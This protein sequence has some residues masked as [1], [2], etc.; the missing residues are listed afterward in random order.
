METHGLPPEPPDPGPLAG[1]LVRRRQSGEF[2]VLSDP[3]RSLRVACRVWAGL[4]ALGLV[5]NH[6][7]GPL[8]S[9]DRPLDDAWPWPASPVAVAAILLSLGLLAWTKRPGLRPARLLDLALA[10]EVLLALG[11]GIVNQWTP[12]TIG[13]SWICVLILVHPLIV[14]APPAKVFAASFAAASMDLVGLAVSGARGVELPPASVLVWTYLPNYLCAML[15]VLPAHV[16]VRLEHHREAA[17]ELGS[18][19]LGELLGR[20][21]MGE[22]YRAEHRLLARPAAVKIVR[23]ELL[24]AADPERFRRIVARFEREARVTARLCSPHTVAVYDFG[25][26]D[27]GTFYYVMELLDGLDLDELVRENGP[28]PAGRAVSVLLQICDSLAEAHDQGLVH[29]DIKPSN[30]MLCRY[31]RRVDFAKVLD[32][33][34]AIPIEERA[35]S[36]I[37]ITT[38]TVL[39]GTPAFMAPEQLLESA[40]VGPAA[41]LYALGCLAYWLLT[42][43][44]V[45]RGSSPVEILVGHARSV[46]EPPSR[47]VELDI[48]PALDAV[49]LACLAKDPAGRP[50]DAEELATRLEEAVAEGD[51]WTPEQARAWWKLHHPER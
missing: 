14:P 19:R 40:P 9:P 25:V 32:F 28:L 15:A 22:V 24:G 46:P 18:H 34:L 31:G 6:G 35:G 13:L 51:R 33:G 3:G 2:G 48:P 26:T 8:V 5:M 49:V 50:R 23:P 17:R 38:E 12:N 29:R 42:G 21:G 11:I 7:V 16:R 44:L 37:R 1:A 47:R 27:E 10:Y 36:E 45:F 41:D 4:W 43:E 20:G 39:A 30:V